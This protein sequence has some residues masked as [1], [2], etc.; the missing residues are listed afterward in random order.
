[1]SVHQST[2]REAT[3][4]IHQ[5]P[6]RYATVLLTGLLG[7]GL[8]G[9]TPADPPVP[10]STSAIQSPSPAAPMSSAPTETGDTSSPVATPSST[11]A[12][13]TVFYVAVD[14]QGKAG[15]Q[16][17]CGDSL[18]AT[19]TEPV[20]FSNQVEAAMNAL[21]ENKSATHGESGLMNA[22]AAS[23][24]RYQ[25]S[26]VSGD[27]VTVELTGM[28]MSGGT[29]D[30]PRIVEQLKHTAKTAAGVG[31][32]LVLVDGTDIEEFLSQK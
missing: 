14:D 13:L 12:R 25:S 18:V 21:L 23:D 11:T 32:A 4:S 3:V 28:P 20:D 2:A 5:K 16:I 22:L 9:C 31:N 26:S 1:M 27:Q 10:G 30:D 6:A 24:M 15:P 7:L 17:G 29:C 19:E 8:S